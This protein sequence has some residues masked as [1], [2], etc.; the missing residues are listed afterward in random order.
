MPCCRRRALLTD[1]KEMRK[2]V[3]STPICCA[4]GFSSFDFAIAMMSAEG[5][6]KCAKLGIAE[7][8]LSNPKKSGGKILNSFPEMFLWNKKSIYY[9]PY[10][11]LNL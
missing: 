1:W 9:R 8:G 10:V 5:K 2:N 6:S 11:S 4:V 3:R 7:T